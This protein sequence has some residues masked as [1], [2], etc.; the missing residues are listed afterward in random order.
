MIDDIKVIRGKFEVKLNPETDP[1][2]WMALY[3]YSEVLD[4]YDP[5]A[6]LKMAKKLYEVQ[7]D[8]S[9]IKFTNRWRGVLKEINR[10]RRYQLK[11][12]VENSKFYEDNLHLDRYEDREEDEED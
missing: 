3:H 9:K 7:L 12:L 1:A 8:R 5:A 6:S 4:A 10:I 11:D 2:A